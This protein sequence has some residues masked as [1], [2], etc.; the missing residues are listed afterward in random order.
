[1]QNTS[2]NLG[3]TNREDYLLKILENAPVGILTFS[4]EWE[5]DF[6]NENYS[7]YGIL[8]NIDSFSLKGLNIL[9]QDLFPGLSI[10][11]ELL[12]LEK[13]YSFEK[14]IRNIPSSGRGFISLFVKVSPVF[15]EGR[16]NGGIIILEDIK[17]IKRPE[18]DDIRIAEQIDK[19]ADKLYDIFLIIDPDRKIKYLSGRDYPKLLPSNQSVIDEHI[20]KLFQNDILNDLQ[21]AISNV[22]ETRSSADLQIDI[23]GQGENLLYKCRIF[24]HLN[25]HRQIKLIYLYFENIDELQSEIRNL[26]SELSELD[27]YATAAKDIPEPILT[28]GFEGEI[29]FYNAAA[30]KCF[31]LSLD[32]M[33]RFIGEVIGQFDKPY[34]NKIKEEIEKSKTWKTNLSIF[35]EDK[36]KETFELKFTLTENERHPVVII[37]SD[38]TV[39]TLTESKLKSSEETFRSIINQAGELICSTD[40][41]GD[42]FYANNTFCNKLGYAPNEV[43]DQSINKFISPDYL[44]SNVFEISLFDQNKTKIEIPL[45]DKKGNIIPTTAYFISSVNE[46]TGKKFFTV[47]FIDI[48]EKYL[49]EKKLELYNAL[50]ESA[51]D[52]IALSSQGKIVLCNDSFC[53]IFGYKNSAELVGRQILDLTSNDDVL[54][55]AEYMQLLEMNKNVPGRFE[56]LGRKK[57]N[58]QFFTEVTAATFTQ[59][60]KIYIVFVTRDI[61]ERKRAQQAIRESEEKYRNITENIEDFLYTFERIGRILRPV[62]Y[63]ASVERIT[64]YS[65][66][67]LLTDSR[68]I[69]KIIHPDDFEDAKKQLKKILLSQ[70]QSST[71]FE[72]RIINKQGNIVWIRNKINVI[73]SHEGLISKVYGLVSDI[74]LRK[75]AQDELKRSTDNLIKLNETKDRFISIISHDLRTPF[76]SILGFTDLLLNDE[77]LSE[78][79]KRQY[80]EFIRESSQS[81]LLLV[82]SLLD[83][84]RLQTGR[85][86]FEPEKTEANKIIENSITTLI[87]TAIQKNIDIRSRVDENL[88]VFAD[89]GLLQQAFNNLI[90]NA[91]KFTKAGGTITISAKPSEQMR[92]FEFSIKDTG[93]GIKKENLDKLFNVDTKYSSE[94]TAGE[95]GTGLGLSLVKEIV[96]KHGGN[97]HVESEYGI[98][99][100]FFFTIPVASSVILLVDDSKTD[101]LLYSKILKSIT[102]DYTVDIAS[103][104]QEAL[105]KIKEYPPAIVITD[106]KMPVMNGYEFVK[107]LKK[108]EM[109][110]KPPV[111]V[112]SGDINRQI[113]SDYSEL[114]IEYV[115]SKPVN[116]SN[117]KQAVEKTIRKGIKST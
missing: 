114:G 24:P 72:L 112:L 34:F 89:K 33:G 86:K 110:G 28:T 46:K 5:I 26:K 111:M 25:K 17:S 74:T 47:Y 81:M 95:K 78:E 104:G 68:L 102:P 55:V 29:I 62:F 21:K 70:I 6:V 31:N 91:I 22:I 32:S 98:G 67:D 35:K 3:F 115:F 116:L 53:E 100:T 4:A 48:S 76:S 59:D 64:G 42:I 80:I 2:D 83:W 9:E 52:G 58:T 12:E 37:C 36:Q 63:T 93:T 19:I 30:Q 82:N 61:T 41:N 71:E 109:N 106:H 92:F 49:A 40:I 96:E 18:E 13:G 50:F 88:Q 27:A 75:K 60:K 87:G 1:M 94:G 51:S 90:S 54:K 85:I 108:L 103:N 107:E 11:E 79:E 23:P 56:F 39:R 16:F 105:E 113:I 66:A 117:F 69:L 38:I 14:E 8:Y 57:D 65:Q 97:I 99:S 20:S 101:R 73:R 15:I 44:T 77:G 10:K 84:T 43:I 45:N 7:K